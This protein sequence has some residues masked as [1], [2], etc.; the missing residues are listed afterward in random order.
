MQ[1]INTIR[2]ESFATK[3]FLRLLCCFAQQLMIQTLR[4][5]LTL[6]L[7]SDA[8]DFSPKCVKHKANS[9]IIILSSL[10][11]LH[12]KY[13]TKREKEIFFWKK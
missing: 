12:I 11:S 10:F 4:F 3:G 1:F 2:T 9:K 6:F 7:C 5:S 8:F 13:K